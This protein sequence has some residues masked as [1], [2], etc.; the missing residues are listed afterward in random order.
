MASRSIVGCCLIWCST[1]ES[2]CCIKSGVTNRRLAILKSPRPASPQGPEKMRLAAGCLAS[3]VRSRLT[4]TH[5]SPPV[6][7]HTM[8]PL[9]QLVILAGVA[10]FIGS[11]PFGLIVGKLKGIDVREHGSKNIGATNVGRLLGKRYF[12]LVTL[13]DALKSMLPLIA[14]SVVMAG[15]PEHE[16]FPLLYAVW[17]GVGVSAML[18]HIFS[19]FLGFKGGKGVATSAGIVLGLWPYYTIAGVLT[20]SLFI[21]IVYITRYISV[22]SILASA[23]FPVFYILLGLSRGWPVFGTQW[24]LLAMAVGVALLIL[25]RH[26]E[27]LKRLRAGTEKKFGQRVTTT[28]PADTISP[29]Q[30]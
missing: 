20:I 19:I 3:L 16:R 6:T 28:P 2:P 22:G 9:W 7:M 12:F 1:K 23:M 26:R 4:F 17:I 14:A 13:L 30:P 29:P 18:G 10:Y 8:A 25:I 5:H 27:N 15:V 24:P 21:L 11:I